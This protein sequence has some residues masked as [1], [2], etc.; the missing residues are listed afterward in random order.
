MARRVPV[1]RDDDVLERIGE[2]VDDRHHLGAA[3]HRQRAA[4]DEAVLHVDHDQYA[5]LSSTGTVPA[6]AEPHRRKQQPCQC[7]AQS[8]APR[9]VDRN[10]SWPPP[11]A[12]LARR[13]SLSADHSRQNPGQGPQMESQTGEP[14]G[15]QRCRERMRPAAS[16]HRARIPGS[17][18]TPRANRNDSGFS[19]LANSGAD[20]CQLT[21]A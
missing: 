4:V 6:A 19:A 5:D 10:L 21:D 17:F 2:L 13:P 14:S 3:L 1:L 11:S 20:G 16:G 12:G 9:G 8:A 18:A 7:P 15:S